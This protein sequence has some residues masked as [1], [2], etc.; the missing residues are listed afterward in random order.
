MTVRKISHNIKK[1]F[2]P[3]HALTQAL[4]IH[5][6]KYRLDPHESVSDQNIIWYVL[7]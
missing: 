1:S 5:A 7:D 6:T 2:I 4:S 3:K